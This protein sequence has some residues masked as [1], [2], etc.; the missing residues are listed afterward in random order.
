MG[1]RPPL[2]FREAK[3][4]QNLARFR[5]ANIANISGSCNASAENPL[6]SVPRSRKKSGD[7]WSTIY[8]VCA[9]NVYPP[10][11]NS[12]RDFGQLYTSIANISG[13]D[14]AIDMRKTALST[15]ITFTFEKNELWSTN[16]RVYAANVYPPEMNAARAAYRLMQLHSPGDVLR[17]RI[18]TPLNCLP[19]RT[20]SA[21][22]PYVGLCPIFHINFYS[23]YLQSI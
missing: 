4:V 15:A 20:Y 10:K 22:R 11:I 9:A 8:R 14:Q 2:E 1:V 16:K 21:V 23:D 5:K 13:T 18:S 3:P 19:S 17:S 7:I 6:Q 12:A